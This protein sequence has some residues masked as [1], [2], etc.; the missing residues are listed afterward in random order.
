MSVDRRGRN[1]TEPEPAFI[2]QFDPLYKEG[3]ITITDQM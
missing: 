2:T 3:H 1:E